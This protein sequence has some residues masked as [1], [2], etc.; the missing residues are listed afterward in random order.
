MK[1]MMA[2]AMACVMVVLLF[3]CGQK[4]EPIDM[5]QPEE[6]EITTNG[7]SEDELAEGYTEEEQEDFLDELDEKTEE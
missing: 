1:R 5:A 6:T 3:G 2:L 7:E 4:A